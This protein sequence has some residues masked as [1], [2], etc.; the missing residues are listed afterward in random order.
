M[1]KRLK[2][3]MEF[4]GV[5]FAVLVLLMG[6][7]VVI[8][9]A[10]AGVVEI[11]IKFA[12][13]VPVTTE[14]PVPPTPTRDWSWLAATATPEATAMSVPTDTPTPVPPTPTP[15]PTDTPTPSPTATRV[16]PTPTRVPPTPAPTETPIPTPTAIPPTVTPVPLTSTTMIVVGARIVEVRPEGGGLVTFRWDGSPAIWEPVE[17]TPD[18]QIRGLYD[19]REFQKLVKPAPISGWQATFGSPAGFYGQ[20]RVGVQVVQ[21]EPYKV[22]N[23]PEVYLDVDFGLNPAGGGDGGCDPDR[24]GRCPDDGGGIVVP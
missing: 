21:T 12:S 10:R 11:T 5:F 2:L 9:A 22:L 24:H 17:R 4:F 15:V 8:E 20:H 14:T 13:A 18:G 3:L 16:P 6:V 23:E 7:V 1:K 19:A